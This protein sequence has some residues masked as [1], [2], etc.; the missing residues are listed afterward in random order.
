MCVLLKKDIGVG[1]CSEV[2][3]K[4]SHCLYWNSLGWMSFQHSVTLQE[5]DSELGVRR[6]GFQCITW[7]WR[8][9]FPPWAD[10]RHSCHQLIEY[11]D[12]QN[13]WSINISLKTLLIISLKKLNSNW[14]K[15]KN[16]MHRLSYQELYKVLWEGGLQAQFHQD[17]SS[18]SLQ[19]SQ[20][21]LFPYTDLTCRQQDKL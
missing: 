18:I 14:L 19:F 16:R 2:G 12:N 5:K 20:L 1:N 11:F 6:H 3:N 21:C 17:T 4:V 10:V 13:F 8:Q 7:R 15:W 9:H